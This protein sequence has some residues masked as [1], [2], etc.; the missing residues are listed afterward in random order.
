[1]QRFGSPS[2]L[3]ASSALALP[4]GQGDRDTVFFLYYVILRRVPAATRWH[5]GQKKLAMSRMNSAARTRSA[6]IDALARARCELATLVTLQH[7]GFRIASDSIIMMGVG[8]AQ[9]RLHDT[10][11]GQCGLVRYCRQTQV[12]RPGR[13]LTA[14]FEGTTIHE[15]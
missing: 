10:S 7:S 3:H 5:P 12:V 4:S 8:Q 2:S 6:A 15:P 1:M 11:R 9:L 14:S 13:V